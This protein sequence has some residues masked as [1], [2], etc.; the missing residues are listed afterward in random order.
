MLTNTVFGN[1]SADDPAYRDGRLEL[2]FQSRTVFLDTGP[3]RL[4]R[5]EFDLLAILARNAGTIVPR[6]TLLS[7]VWG[8]SPLA[9]TRTL[10]VHVRRLRLR[11]KDYGPAHIKTVYGAGYRL[12]CAWSSFPAA[13]VACGA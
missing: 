5:K 6:R 7:E 4:R 9:R 1:D 8:Y 10:D 2:N 11:L 3:V 13:A 12:S